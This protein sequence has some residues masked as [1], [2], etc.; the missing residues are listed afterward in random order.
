MSRFLILILLVLASSATQAIDFA[1]QAPRDL[2]L[3]PKNTPLAVKNAVPRGYALIVGISE[4]K[5]LDASKQ[6][7]FPESDA[8]ALYRVLINHE[9][10]AF[11]AENVHFLKGSQATLAN[12]RHELETWLPS[13]AQPADRVVVYFAGHGFVQNGRGYLAPYDVDPDKLDA[14]A[15]PMSSLGDV[16]ANKVGAG[17]KVL[18]TDACHSGK[19]N[20]ETTNE[21]LEQQFKSLPASFLTLTATTEREQSFEDPNL[22]T[23]FGFFTYYLVQ[24]FSGYADND[25]CDGRITA[26]ELIEYVRT[27]VRRYARE[28]QLSQTPTARGDYEPEMLLGVAQGCLSDG[29]GDA[30]S[31]LGTAVIESN[32]DDVDLYLDGKLIGRLSKDKP[33]TLPGLSSGMH[34][35]RGVREGYEPERKEVMIPPGQEVAVSLRIRYVRQIK[36]P[37]QDLNEQGE[38]LLF[39]RR[40]SMSLLNL[41]P[42]ERKQSESDLH[43]AAAYFEKALDIDP[44]FATAAYHLGQVKQLLMKHDESVAAFRRAIAIDQTHIDARI[45]CAAVLIEQGDPD[46]AIRELT[47]ALRLEADNDVA[48][49]M[50]AR[51]YWDKGVW[52]RAIDSADQAI[53][54]KPSNAQAHLWRAD[55]LRQLAAASTDPKVQLSLYAD[56]RSGYRTFLDLTNFSTGLGSKLA[57]HFIGLGIGARRHA[58][59]QVAYDSLRSA[60]FLGL[61]LSEQKVGNPLKARDYCKR[62]LKHSP[63]DPIGYFLLGN[64]NRDLFNARQSCSFLKD[65]RTSYTKMLEINPHLSESRNARNY[66]G[67]IDGFLP[68]LKCGS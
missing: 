65:A 16:L 61:C 34:E 12:I 9:G 52:A 40:S 33:M 38:K 62:A 28:R 54:L 42:M 68:Q 18:L 13:V 58:D 44:G 64:V 37:A 26:D 25:P 32:M 6:L 21:A 39:T 56:A 15:Y 2:I 51:A 66:V 3:A 20:G 48:H 49:S 46:E 24:A 4:Y 8:D 53:K 23:G 7:R 5:N 27:N 43:R 41:V 35:F 1:Q 59:R 30:P 45:E 11:P 50:L 57:F 19:I 67:Q 47:E 31:M 22:G 63:S 36:K 14:T 55:S 17:W 29:N 10:G 60:G